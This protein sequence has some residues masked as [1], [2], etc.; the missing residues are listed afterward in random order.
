MSAAAGPKGQE[1]A[2][3]ELVEDLRTLARVPSAVRSSRSCTFAS[4][5]YQS[6]SSSHVKW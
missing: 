4:S 3:Q 6:H 2:E 1:L 5:R